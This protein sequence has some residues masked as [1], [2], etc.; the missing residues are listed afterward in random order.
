MIKPLLSGENNNADMLIYII[1]I[2]AGFGKQP[3]Y[4]KEDINDVKN[5]C[6]DTTKKTKSVL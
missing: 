6:K 4:V 1:T 2:N 5:F 3:C